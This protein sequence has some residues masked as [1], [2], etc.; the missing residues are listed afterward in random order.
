M[1]IKNCTEK[2]EGTSVRIS[3]KQTLINPNYLSKFIDFERQ[4]PRFDDN[5]FVIEFR[6]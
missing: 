4:T 2:G 3:N 1:L 6:Q 5:K